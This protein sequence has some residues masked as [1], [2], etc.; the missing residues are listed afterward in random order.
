MYWT[1]VM[2]VMIDFSFVRTNLGP[3]EVRRTSVYLVRYT[4]RSIIMQKLWD[5]ILDT[6]PVYVVENAPLDD[7]SRTAGSK[8]CPIA[9]TQLRDK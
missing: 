9:S 3:S 4:E 5:Q 6:I 8:S 1:D 2:K 7:R